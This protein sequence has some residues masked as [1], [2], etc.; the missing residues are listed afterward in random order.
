MSK[1]TEYNNSKKKICELSVTIASIERDTDKEKSRLMYDVYRPMIHDLEKERDDKIH[2]VEAKSSSEKQELNNLIESQRVIVKEVEQVYVMID[3]YKNN[4]KEPFKPEVCLYVYSHKD[5]QGNYISD[6]RKVVFESFEV[7]ES[8][9]YKGMAMY[10]VEN[11][12]PTNKYSL[13]IAYSSL[14]PDEIFKRG[15]SYISSVH[16]EHGTRMTIIKKG[17]NK[18]DLIAWYHKKG[19]PQTV[20]DM[21]TGHKK[22][23]EQYE[24]AIKLYEIKEWKK[25]YLQWKKDYY[26]NHYSQGTETPEY[27][28]ICK[29]LKSL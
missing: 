23:E 20:K 3:V 1:I 18:E 27:K 7:L 10:V 17:P 28:A 4:L 25:G 14:F 21:I 24:E 26:E 19:L 13:V 16:T 5:E 2:I 6:S 12:K 11:S 22:L 9:K 8:D 15:F 29:E